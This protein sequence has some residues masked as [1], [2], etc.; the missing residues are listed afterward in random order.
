MNLLLSCTACTDDN[1]K[2]CRNIFPLVMQ[3]GNEPC[4]SYPSLHPSAKQ[5]L[6]VGGQSWKLS[7]VCIKWNLDSLWKIVQSWFYFFFFSYLWK[8]GFLSSISSWL[9]TEILQNGSS[10]T[11]TII[12]R[13]E[14]QHSPGQLAESHGAKC[15]KFVLRCTSNL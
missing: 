8:D 11:G 4:L 5:E 12:F 15:L 13:P 9:V 3:M 2:S 1:N 6:L 10:L 14:D 7:L